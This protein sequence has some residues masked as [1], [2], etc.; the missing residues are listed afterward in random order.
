MRD[1]YLYLC[2]PIRDDLTQFVLN[3]VKGGVDIVQIRDKNASDRQ[4]IDSAI[5][6]KELLSKFDVP[7][8]VN[9]RPDLALE[10]DADG[11]HVGQ[12]DVSVG[13]CRRILGNDKIVGLS[14]HNK[15]ELDRS[16][17]LY[18]DYISVGPIYSTPTK[19]GRTPTGLEYL[20]YAVKTSSKIFFVTGNCNLDTI[21]ILKKAGGKRFVVVRSLTESKDPQIQA[22]LL[23]QEILS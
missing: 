7:L 3:C 16:L 6:L 12:D 1:R 15:D 9:D 5:K 19:K 2:T 10:A 14:T 11:V 20:D 22:R 8:I 13:I 17:T 18:V 4:I 23:K 21:P